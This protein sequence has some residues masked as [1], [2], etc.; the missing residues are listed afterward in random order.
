MSVISKITRYKY[1]I[2]GR[3]QHCEI[4]YCDKKV[5]KEL[6]GT[7]PRH[8]SPLVFFFKQPLLVPEAKPRND[9]D[10]F[11]NIRGDI[12]LFRCFTGVIDTGEAN[13]FILVLWFFPII[14]TSK[15]M[16]RW[17]HW[18]S[19]LPGI[20]DTGK[21]CIAG[22]VD[23]S[24]VMHHRCCWYRAVK[25]TN[26]AG[27]SDTGE[28]CFRWCQWHHRKHASPVSLIPANTCFAGVNDTGE[29]F[30]TSVVDTGEAL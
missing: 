25:I 6:K 13:D 1:N 22:V 4:K 26:F 12:R 17:C 7:V 23:T 15:D 5:L 29:Y 28:A 3:C 18:R 16:L 11:S 20:N 8:F 10:F 2:A 19:L 21:E 27:V 24:D 30:F 9:F 14:D